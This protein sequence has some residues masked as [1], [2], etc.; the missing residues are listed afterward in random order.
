MGKGKKKACKVSAAL[1]QALVEI[2]I[3]VIGA[4]IAEAI[5]RLIF[6]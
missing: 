4:V 2:L 3:T 1:R 5:I 6:G